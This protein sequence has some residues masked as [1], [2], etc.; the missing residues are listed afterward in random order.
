MNFRGLGLPLAVGLL[1]RVAVTTV[2]HHWG[3]VPFTSDD[4]T[5]VRFAKA[6][7]A[8][9]RLETA[10][11][12][13]GYTFFLAPFM[14]LGDAAFPL[15]RAV[16]VVLGVLTVAIVSRTTGLLYGE[17]AARIAAWWTALY[18]P[19]VFMTGRIMSETWF[20][21]LLTA[22]LYEFLLAD[23]EPTLRRNA[24]AGAI[25]GLASIFRSNLVPMLP[26]IPLWQLVRRGNT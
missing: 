25:F 5:Y 19:L 23:R 15:I 13:I 2:V 18:P 24:F 16:Q 1:A 22:S 10:H 14:G 7:F 17:R 21:A 9:G 3:A 26:F 12:P 8:H 20:I 11:F 6:L 4:A